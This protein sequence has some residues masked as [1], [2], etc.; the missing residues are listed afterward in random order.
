MPSSYKTPISL[1]LLVLSMKISWCAGIFYFILFRSL[2]RP[3]YAAGGEREFGVGIGHCHYSFAP[4]RRSIGKC[5][6][7][8]YMISLLNSFFKESQSDLE[9]F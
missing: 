5:L 8:D 6:V 4:F 1:T 7:D 2:R 3:L 9:S